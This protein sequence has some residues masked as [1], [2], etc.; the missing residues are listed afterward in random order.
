MFIYRHHTTTTLETTKKKNVINQVFALGEVI[1]LYLLMRI[2]ERDRLYCNRMCKRERQMEF[3]TPSIDLR[4]PSKYTSSSFYH[5]SIHLI[6]IQSLSI[7]ILFVLLK[8]IIITNTIN[9]NISRFFLNS[10]FQIYLQ[11]LLHNTNIL[12][13]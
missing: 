12:G 13:M 5:F 11:Y 2:Y 6:K 9:T 10:Y 3:S 8:N 7:C 4:A 1:F